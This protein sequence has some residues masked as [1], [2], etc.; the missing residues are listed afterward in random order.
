MIVTLVLVALFVVGYSLGAI[1]IN[2][3]SLFR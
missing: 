2:G 1:T 3:H